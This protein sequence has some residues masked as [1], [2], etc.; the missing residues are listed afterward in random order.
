[1][2]FNLKLI[3]LMSLISQSVSSDF[4]VGDHTDYS[5]LA[6][7]L[8]AK[9]NY[10]NLPA[11]TAHICKEVELLL[12]AGPRGKKTTLMTASPNGIKQAISKLPDRKNLYDGLSK[13]DKKLAMEGLA[14]LFLDVNEDH[15]LSHYL[16]SL[17]FLVYA[18]NTFDPIIAEVL[19]AKRSEVEYILNF[20]L[21]AFNLL[22]ARRVLTQKLD[23]IWTAIPTTTKDELMQAVE[24]AKAHFLPGTN[25][26]A[27][28]EKV[29]TIITR[30]LQK[31]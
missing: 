28:E 5:L 8:A 11:A 27:L 6:L 15:S 21:G 29:A 13:E 10:S 19:K 30:R 3:L 14:M 24:N 22:T 9:H 20:K 18:G 4:N 31:N 17:L 1:M 7:V 2:K 26:R 23:A 12:P 25:T 16:R